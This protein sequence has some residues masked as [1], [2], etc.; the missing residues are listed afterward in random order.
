[1]NLSKKSQRVCIKVSNLRKLYGSKTNLE[2][3]LDD[4]DNVYCGRAGRI[5]ITENGEKTY[6]GYEGSKWANPYTLK[7]YPIDEC[8]D[9]YRDYITK[10][11]EDDSDYD[12]NELKGKN[13]GCW[14]NPKDRCHVDVLLELLEES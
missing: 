4:S 14:C 2:T 7:Q 13:L 11:I 6:F 1:M 8:L 5:F 3:W 12:L 9:L 10:K